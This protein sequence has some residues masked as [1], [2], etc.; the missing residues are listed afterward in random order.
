MRQAKYRP[1]MVGQRPAEVAQRLAALWG[2]AFK[3]KIADRRAHEAALEAAQARKAAPGSADDIEWAETLWDLL[4]A[5]AHTAL[6]SRE[7]AE[8]TDLCSVPQRPCGEGWR[9]ST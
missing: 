3:Q 1:H 9:A 5:A 2:L 8:L 6:G 4:R 7:G